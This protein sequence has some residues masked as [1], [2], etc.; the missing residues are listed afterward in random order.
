MPRVADTEATLGIEFSLR[1]RMQA[2]HAVII[3]TK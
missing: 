3:K 2:M 1:D